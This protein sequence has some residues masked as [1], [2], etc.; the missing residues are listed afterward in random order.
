MAKNILRGRVIK[1]RNQGKSYSEIR[2]TIKVSKSTLSLW[3]RNMPLSEVQLRKLRDNNPIRIE[4]YREAMKRKRKD[5]QVVSHVRAVEDI[6]SISEREFFIAGL[7]LYWGE[8]AKAADYTLCVSNT[9]PSVLVCFIKWLAMLGVDS[10]RLRIRLHLYSD[11]DE[12]QEI[13]FWQKTLQVPKACFRKSY[14][15]KSTTSDLSYKRKFIHGTCN[16]IFGNRDIWEY[17]ME[18]LEVIREKYT[19][20]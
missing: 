19:R 14:I 6:A 20:P 18:C 1:L 2:S 15:K 7:F 10:S 16:V 8:G 12:Q 17:V 4:K 13:A 3:L 5:R 11:M 9:D